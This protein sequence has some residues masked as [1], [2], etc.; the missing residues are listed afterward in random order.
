[1]GAYGTSHLRVPI[2]NATPA[3]GLSTGLSNPHLTQSN[4]VDSIAPWLNVTTHTQYHAY[5]SST[6]HTRQPSRMG[7]EKKSESS[8]A[9]IIA[10]SIEVVDLPKGWP[11]KLLARSDLV[12]V[13]AT[14]ANGG[15][16]STAQIKIGSAFSCDHHC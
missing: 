4:R 15:D 6:T 5:P 11:Q 14:P 16:I 3:A 2:S 12:N 10:T 7:S 8:G 9:A 1:M 13:I